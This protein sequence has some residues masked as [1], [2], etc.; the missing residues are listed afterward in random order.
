MKSKA[1]KAVKI[2]VI[3]LLSLIT[4][5]LIIIALVIN[6]VFTPAKLTPVVLD[7]ANQSLDAKLDLQSVDLT[8]FS[9]FPDFS[10]RIKNGTL[11]SKAINDILWTKTDSLVSFKECL[12]S[13]NPIAYLE[14]NRVVIK[15]ILLEDASLYAFKNKE[16]KSNWNIMKPS[17]DTVAV[18]ADTV[19]TGF[20]SEIDIQNIEFKNTNIVFDDRDTRMYARLD[21][22]N[23]KVKLSL[24]KENSSLD[25][26]FDNKNVIFWQQGELLVNKIAASLRTRID[27]NKP[28]QT[29]TLSDTELTVNGI[30]L[31]AQGTFVRDT[32]AKT[33]DVDIQYGLHT[34]S[35]KTV[36]EMIPESILKKA[37][38]SAKGEVIVNGT[39]K[40]LYGEEK[41]PAASLKI[42]IKDASAKYSGFEY[43]IDH[44]SADLDGHIDLMRAKPSYLD[45][46]IFRFKGA[47]TEVL[48][49]ARV[50]DLLTDP[51]ITLNTK[52]KIDLDALAKTFP[53][54]EGVS[55]GGKLDA[56][57]SLKC[58]VSSIRKQDIGR[59]NVNGDL[60]LNAFSL[61]DK[62]HDFELTSNA[63]LNFSG[64]NTLQ[65][66]AEVHQ[67]ILHSKE[68]SSTVESLSA[69]ITTSNPQDTTRIVDL[70]CNFGLNK[71]KTKIGD[72]ISFYSGR[73]NAK[74]TIAPGRRD[75][76]KP[77]IGLTFRTDSLFF[78]A[79]QTKLGLDL[80]GFEVSAEKVR[81]SLWLPNGIVGFSK[82]FISTPEYGLPIRLGKTKV[83]LDKGDITL[84]NA[85]VRIGKS[86]L[87]VNGAVYKP[88]RTMMKKEVLK[89]RLSIESDNLDCNQLINALSVAGD[90]TVMDMIVE[91]SERNISDTLPTDMRL[92]VVPRNIDFELRTNLK[93]VSY[94][95]MLFENVHGSVEVKNQAVYLRDLSMRALEADMK[96]AMVYKAD[97]VKGYTGFDFKIDD[98]NVGKLVE[99]I[100]SLDTIV[101]MLR[102]FKGYV[103][104]DIVAES[105][106]DSALNI[107]IPTLKSAIKIKGD[108]LVLMDGETF[109]EIS[110]MLMFKNKKQNL[111][112]SISVNVTVEDG[113]VNIYPFL[114]EIDRYRA[115]VGGRQGLD[116]SLDYHISVLKSPVPFK[117][118]INI[119]GN[120]DKMKIR[121]GG[122]KYKDAVTP[123]EIRKVDSTRINMGN[124][125]IRRFRRVIN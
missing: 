41:I 12:I 74:I 9:T 101:P 73:S 67:L 94:D 105:V 22:A 7:M 93:K 21:S 44:L 2:L 86:N 25:L 31:S 63:S 95:K 47:H 45:L 100:P 90:S 99:F 115:A 35:V 28:T 125:I 3:S 84:H 111:V 54:Q 114:I 55:I 80:A 50:S 65:A 36:L 52:S 61:K 69:D 83:T 88:Y 102:S 124:E 40:G 39:I 59:I 122:A 85:A 20:N 57:L 10:L 13:V 123:V 77:L 106:L 37:T 70:E 119:K 51:Y 23:M 38:V 62:N 118:G 17:V 121:F 42:Q 14:D 32:I 49:D 103:D 92:F 72:T 1:V 6:F 81:D 82:L 76:T 117:M 75:I 98:I 24:A 18:E 107:Q 19:K 43:G 26:S 56:N 89:A 11:V 46:K 112:D 97:A 30:K 116:M 4:I 33:T 48:A 5:C 91:T 8:F 34:P 120:L 110:K 113:N 87:V 60:N 66:K 15:N 71:F 29:F 68:L 96:A 53:L 58:H 64:D 78:R 108:S 79:H 27:I 109:A 16:G 104:F